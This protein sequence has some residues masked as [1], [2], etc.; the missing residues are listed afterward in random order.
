[1]AR[2][3][4]TR[5]LTQRQCEAVIWTAKGFSSREIADLMGCSPKTAN[6]L[7]C[8]GMKKLGYSKGVQVTAWA[9]R[10]GMVTLTELELVGSEA[11][12]KKLTK[13]E[14]KEN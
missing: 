2:Y 3:S 10:M 7:R 9:L 8:V 13:M 5:P 14:E 6:S 1:M 4:L 11:V 12:T